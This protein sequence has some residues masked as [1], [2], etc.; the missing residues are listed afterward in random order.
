MDK[1]I[2]LCIGDTRIAIVTDTSVL[3]CAVRMMPD[4]IVVCNGNNERSL[5]WV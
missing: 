2:T 4:I 3:Q 1:V 5:K